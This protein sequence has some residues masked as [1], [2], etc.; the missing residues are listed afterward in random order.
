MDSHRP[1]CTRQPHPKIQP[2]RHASTEITEEE[3]AVLREG[4]TSLSAHS[5]R[6]VNLLD[7]MAI[8]DEQGKYSMETQELVDL[9]R[10]TVKAITTQPAPPR[11]L[12]N[13]IR[14]QRK[15]EGCGMP[16]IEASV[17]AIRIAQGISPSAALAYMGCLG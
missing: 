11:D 16:P 15:P 10:R 2:S 7:E 14:L 6:A 13:S 4:P 9:L 17:A 1:L 8:S 12:S 5:T 3:A